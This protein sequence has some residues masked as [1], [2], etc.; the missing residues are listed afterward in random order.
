MKSSN[1]MGI[2]ILFGN[3]DQ[4]V[5]QDSMIFKNRNDRFFGVVKSS[6]PDNTN[7]FETWAEKRFLVTSDEATDEGY[8]IITYGTGNFL[9]KVALCELS[10]NY[11][12]M[13]ELVSVKDRKKVN[14]TSIMPGLQFDITLQGIAGFRFMDCFKISGLPH[15]YS[16]NVIYQIINIKQSVTDGK[17]TTTLTCGLRPIEN[18][19][20]ETQLHYTSYA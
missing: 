3:G 1:K 12:L 9:K 6:V 8:H 14:H 10:S 18:Q 11:D 2:Q 7:R 15:T 17:W 20:A 19:I 5:T 13:M 16:V 4:T